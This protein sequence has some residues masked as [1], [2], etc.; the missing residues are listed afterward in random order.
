MAEKV[1][2]GKKGDVPDQ[3]TLA[4][5]QLTSRAPNSDELEILEK[6]HE[7]QLAYFTAEPESAQQFL[8]IGDH[9]KQ[10]E[11][12]ATQLAALTVVVEAIMNLSEAITKP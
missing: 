12:D 10:D 5:R 2:G 11:S 6:L 7:E 3:I 9:R 1:M 4:F 8:E